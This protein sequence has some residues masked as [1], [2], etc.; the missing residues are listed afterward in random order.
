MAGWW[1]PP[2]IST[3]LDVVA[4]VPVADLDHGVD[5]VVDPVLLADLAEVGHQV[6]TAVPPGVDGL[7]VAKPL[8]VGP[9]AD[10]DHVV[11]V[12]A[13]PL[14][15]HPLVALVRGDH[16]IGGPER[17]SLEE[18]QAGPHQRRAPI[19]ELGVVHLGRQIVVVEQESGPG[20]L[21]QP[22]EREVGLGRVADVQ[23]VDPPA[24]HLPAQLQRH[25]DEAPGE[26]GDEADGPRGLERDRSGG[27]AP[28]RSPR[29]GRRGPCRPGRCR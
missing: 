28:P 3:Q 18:Q 19:A 15:G 21:D 24:H 1:G 27:S 25:P 17:P 10:H 13:A 23:H 4:T 7:D 22:A 9:A 8:E 16:E 6:A 5:Q 2:P 20:G 26:L 11:G 29:S 14:D 12:L